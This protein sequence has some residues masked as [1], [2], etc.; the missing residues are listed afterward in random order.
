[1]K[2]TV[3]HSAVK[4]IEVQKATPTE[5]YENQ[6]ITAIAFDF[7]T[8]IE[9]GFPADFD[10]AEFIYLEP[11]FPRGYETFNKRVD[12]EV[13]IGFGALM[14][15]VSKY[16]RESGK[17]AFL[18]GD[19]SFARYFCKE[20]KTMPMKL[21]VHNGNGTLYYYN[22]HLPKFNSNIDLMNYLFSKYEIGLDFF[23][24]YGMTGQIAVKHGKKV[25]L[26]DINPTCIGYIK[27][28]NHKWYES[29]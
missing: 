3:Y 1:M 13:G 28:N 22:S 27:E 11:P 17:P 8:S 23:C 5:R 21:D 16:M 9:N 10:K 12:K 26:A 29:L 15:S 7:E 24:G 2:K 19:K 4:N 14:S 20:V 18:I 25:V 6:D